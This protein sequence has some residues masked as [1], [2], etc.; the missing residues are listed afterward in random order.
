MKAGFMLLEIAFAMTPRERRTVVI[1]KYMDA[2]ASALGFFLIGFGSISGYS[3]QCIGVKFFDISDPLLWFFKFTFAS[4]AAT[5]L[6]GCLVS[7]KYKLRLPAAFISAFVISGIIHPIVALFIWSDNCH[8]FSPYR[9]CRHLDCL[10]C[11]SFQNKAYFLDFAGGGAVHLLGGTAGLMVCLFAKLQ[12]WRDKK[13]AEAE[14]IDQ[15]EY[16]SVD[17]STEVPAEPEPEPKGFWDWMYPE[18]AGNENV[19][20]AALGVLILW[21]AWFAF[22]CG[23][24]ESVESGHY[25]LYHAVPSRIA[26]NMILCCAAGGIVAVA[27]AC[28]AQLRYRTD[29]INANE[30]ANGI[31]SCLVAITASCPFVNYWAAC[32]IGITAVIVYHLG[33]YAEYKLGIEDTA[34]VVPVHGVCGLWSLLAVAVFVQYKESLCYLHATFEGLCFCD[35]RLPHLSWIERVGAQVIGSLVILALGLSTGIVYGILYIIPIQ[36]FVSVIAKLTR[37]NHDLRGRKLKELKF[38]GGFL[39]TSPKE[40]FLTGQENLA[41]VILPSNTAAAATN[42]NCGHTEYV[43]VNQ[44]DSSMGYV[45][46]EELRNLS[47]QP[48]SSES[49]QP[50]SS[51]ASSQQA[52]VISMSQPLLG[53]SRSRP[54]YRSVNNSDSTI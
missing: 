8:S 4:N 41:D 13:A 47:A 25:G 40:D 49:S 2:F 5:I 3:P 17:S 20:M 24:T 6:G 50:S 18:M 27:I 7:N 44:S 32:V 43:S 36:P 42:V 33:C 9:F 34:R 23:S 12:H 28:W 10:H 22:N 45:S 16:E 30:I 31:L 21:F 11:S 26:I 46:G 52:T 1:Y 29:S 37:L 38:Y 15:V 35:L 39:L 51:G 14:I 48:R 53:Y 54:T 19:E